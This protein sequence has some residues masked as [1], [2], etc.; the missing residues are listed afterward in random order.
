[1]LEQHDIEKYESLYQKSN[2]FEISK[3]HDSKYPNFPFFNENNS[4][5]KE[6]QLQ[7]N[8]QINPGPIVSNVI[9]SFDIL[10]Q[11]LSETDYLKM[12]N[13]KGFPDFILTYGIPKTIGII[14]QDKNDSETIKTIEYDNF[15]VDTFLKTLILCYYY[16]SSQHET[17][18]ANSNSE[19]TASY[20]I[21]DKKMILKEKIVNFSDQIYGVKTKLDNFIEK[22]LDFEEVIGNYIDFTKEEEKIQLDNF[23]EKVLDF[24]EV[25]GNYIDFTQE[26]VKIQLDNFKEKV[27]DFKEVIRN[28]KD[29][30]QEGKKFK[31]DN[32]IEKVLD[33]K[34]II[35]NFKD[36]FYEGEKTNINNLLEESIILLEKMDSLIDKIID[37]QEELDSQSDIIHRREKTK[38]N[39]HL[40]EVNNLQEEKE[41]LSDGVNNLQ[42][43]IDNLLDK[44]HGSEKRKNFDH[45]EEVNNSGEENENIFDIFY[46]KEKTKIT[47]ILFE[48]LNLKGEKDNFIGE[49]E[50]DYFN[51]ILGEKTKSPENLIT[52][53][54]V[55][56]DANADDPPLLFSQYSKSDTP[57]PIIEA[58]L[59]ILHDDS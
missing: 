31:N 22:V 8:S 44:I 38:T 45:L 56:A 25:I 20:N 14:K 36:F 50:K 18:D 1:M 12:Q 39:D 57:G 52:V 51:F 2:D 35:E 42:E 26:G 16:L 40:D 19:E 3:Y 54:E 6:Y 7:G 17:Y 9:V 46:G 37:L 30:T 33:F 27:L 15:V 13:S 47:N 53:T 59:S 11:Q 49:I 10:N 21:L 5:K 55:E 48:A 58:Y 32:F 23:I 28:F 41:N 4:F 29:F 43:K 24:K 34:E